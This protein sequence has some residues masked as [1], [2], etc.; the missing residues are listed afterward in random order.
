MPSN[1]LTTLPH[2]FKPISSGYR[3]LSQ[4]FYLFSI[5]LLPVSPSSSLSFVSSPSSHIPLQISLSFPPYTLQ[6]IFLCLITFLHIS[7]YQH[8]SLQSLPSLPFPVHLSLFCP[9][10]T[11]SLNCFCLLLHPLPLHHQH[12]LFTIIL[13]SPL[14]V[15]HLFSLSSSTWHPPP[16]SPILPLCILT[17]LLLFFPLSICQ[18]GGS[19]QE[20]EFVECLRDVFL[21]QLVEEPTR[22][23]AV[24]DWV[25]CNEPE[26]IR[27]LK[28]CLQYY[29]PRKL[30]SKLLDLGLNTSLRNWILDFLTNRLQSLRNLLC[31]SGREHEG[32]MVVLTGNQKERTNSHQ[33][34]LP[35]LLSISGIFHYN[36]GFSALAKTPDYALQF[37]P[38]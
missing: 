16:I 29:I 15:C 13:H 36:I 18:N 3:H 7:P 20:R 19:T 6:L 14:A 17:F 21:E 25:L 10:S 8:Y 31:L 5:Y 2:F 32:K 9:S 28:L 4:P 27:E 24:L 35:D 26:V 33:K 23:S 22:G 12:P 11:F 37:Q 30:I 34:T 1:L 38:T